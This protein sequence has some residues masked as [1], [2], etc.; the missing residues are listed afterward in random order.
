MITDHKPLVSIFQNKQLGSHCLYRIK[1]LHQDRNF[2]LT[3]KKGAPNPADYTPRH[4]TPLSHLPKHIQQE[5]EEY[6]KLCWFLRRSPYMEYLSIAILREHTNKDEILQDLSANILHNRKP[7]ATSN[8]AAYSKVF[9]EL[10][11]SDGGLVMRGER[12]V[13][14]TSPIDLAVERLIKVVIREKAI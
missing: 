9:D 7:E 10:I 11:I 13:L 12:E 3:G 1:L 8:C 5:S 14:P 6:S 4:A 2:K